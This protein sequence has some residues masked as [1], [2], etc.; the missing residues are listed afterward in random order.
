[1]ARTQLRRLPGFLQ[2]RDRRAAEY[3]RQLADVP[4][5]SQ[6]EVRPRC[7]RHGRW[8]H[9]ILLDGHDRRAVADRLRAAGID[10]RGFYHPL[11][12]HPAYALRDRLPACESFA[13]RGLVLPSGNRLSAQQ[14]D[15]VCIALRAAL[16]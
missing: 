6:Q 3:A 9:T 14:V 10:T 2:R 12:L 7:T 15:A 16:T 1:V 5:L 8:A 11:H 4:G 13:S